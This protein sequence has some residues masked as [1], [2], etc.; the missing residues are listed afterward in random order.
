MA[1]KSLR[2]LFDGGAGLA[3]EAMAAQ[4]AEA[5]RDAYARFVS[6]KGEHVLTLIVPSEGGQDEFIIDLR[7]VVALHIASEGQ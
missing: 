3:V 6:G 5:A 2:F 4:S 1:S 7:K